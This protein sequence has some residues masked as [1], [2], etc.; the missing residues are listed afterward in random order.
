MN[1]LLGNIRERKDKLEEL[2]TTLKKKF[3]GIDHEIDK[4]VESITTWYSMPDII[5]HPII[6]NLW[7]LTGNGKT[8]L[9]RTLVDFLGFNNRFCEIQLSDTASNDKKK[10]NISSMVLSSG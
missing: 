10:D 5:T 2:R 1:N 4:I 9:V 7:S 3:F 6:V 8:D